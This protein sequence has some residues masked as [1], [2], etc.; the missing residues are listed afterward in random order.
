VGTVN[1]RKPVQTAK[2]KPTKKTTGEGVNQAAAR[3][4]REATEN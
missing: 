2:P 3:V 4:V 1:K